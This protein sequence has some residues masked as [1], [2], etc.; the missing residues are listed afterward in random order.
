MGGPLESEFMYGDVDVQHTCF[1]ET[2]LSDVHTRGFSKS[3][4]ISSLVRDP[5]HEYKKKPRAFNSFDGTVCVAPIISARNIAHIK[6]LSHH[7]IPN[8]VH[9][10]KWKRTCKGRG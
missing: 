7:L 9:N 5:P 10:A 6:I 8:R 1:D 2:K 3:S 4:E